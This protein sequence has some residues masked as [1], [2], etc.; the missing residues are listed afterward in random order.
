MYEP[1]DISK[2]WDLP[3]DYCSCPECGREF[4]HHRTLV[5]AQS[6][7][8]MPCAKRRGFAIMRPVSAEA[9]IANLKK[10]GI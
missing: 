9:F 2:K 5:D 6:E 1:H 3:K 10:Y 7:M 4:G 8:C